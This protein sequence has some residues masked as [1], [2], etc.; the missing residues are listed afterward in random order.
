MRALRC[1]PLLVFGGISIFGCA[2][3]VAPTSPS[4][5]HTSAPGAAIAQAA[6]RPVHKPRAPIPQPKPEMGITTPMKGEPAAA[7]LAQTRLETPPC[8]QASSDSVEPLLR[9]MREAV[10]EAQKE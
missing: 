1:G 10:N 2:Q 3:H 6:A 4:S 9:E 5:L 8:E 7:A